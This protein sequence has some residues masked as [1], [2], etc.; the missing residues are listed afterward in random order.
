VPAD[1]GPPSYAVLA[2]LVVSLRRELA[3]SVAVVEETRA[4]LGQAR[5][6]DR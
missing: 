4:E 5:G 6:T 1:D 2:A 3:D